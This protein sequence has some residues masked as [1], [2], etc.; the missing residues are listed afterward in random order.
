MRSSTCVYQYHPPTTAHTSSRRKVNLASDQQKWNRRAKIFRDLYIML[1]A[2]FWTD[3]RDD[4]RVVGIKS[5]IRI[6]SKIGNP[7]DRNVEWAPTLTKRGVFATSSPTVLIISFSD[8]R[9]CFGFRIS[10]PRASRPLFAN[11]V[12]PFPPGYQ[13]RRQ[14]HHRQQRRLPVAK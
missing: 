6:K 2:G 12:W 14:D 11:L 8:I 3:E 5:E 7:N 9:I 10:L 1:D 4:R 13:R